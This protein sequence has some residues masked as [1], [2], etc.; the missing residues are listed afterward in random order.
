MLH[1]LR[2]GATLGEAELPVVG[3]RDE[4]HVVGG[5]RRGQDLLQTGA[6]VRPQAA[7]DAE[8]KLGAAAGALWQIFLC[9]YPIFFVLGHLHLVALTAGVF[10]RHT[11]V[12]VAAAVA[13]QL[14]AGTHEA[15]VVRDDGAA[16][17]R[18]PTREQIRVG[19][20]ARLK[21]LL[22]V[23]VEGLVK[24]PQVENVA[25]LGGQEARAEIENVSE[26]EEENQTHEHGH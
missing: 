25:V 7:A 1:G 11:G 12:G 21:L 10:L 15:L 13:E 14:A 8:L 6:L 19:E 20:V 4:H 17:D 22:Q 5:G 18:V 16:L 24:L 3:H 2:A 9:F 26:D 23:P